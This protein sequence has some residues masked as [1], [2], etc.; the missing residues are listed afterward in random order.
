M[1]KNTLRIIEFQARA[2]KALKYE[3]SLVAVDGVS[4]EEGGAA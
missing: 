1:K 3:G 2:V 4:V